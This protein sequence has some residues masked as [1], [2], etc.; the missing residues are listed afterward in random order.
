MHSIGQ[1]LGI[2]KRALMIFGKY[3]MP[4]KYCKSHGYVAPKL[5]KVVVKPEVLFS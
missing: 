3:K 1:P 5:D 4:A 2:F